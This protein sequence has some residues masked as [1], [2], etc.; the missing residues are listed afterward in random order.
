MFQT[1]LAHP[2][3]KRTRFPPALAVLQVRAPKHIYELLMITVLGV[4]CWHSFVAVAQLVEPSETMNCTQRM[5][6]EN[7]RRGSGE[8]RTA[9]C[10]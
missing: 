9:P 10:A 8:P 5:W 6:L 7:P 3:L 4:L 1:Y 2:F